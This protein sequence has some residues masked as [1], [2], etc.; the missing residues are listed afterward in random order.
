M[1]DR[2]GMTQFEVDD[3][4]V[5]D[6]LDASFPASDPPPWT[7]GHIETAAAPTPEPQRRP[8]TRNT[9]KGGPR[10]SGRGL[11]PA[12]MACVQ[13]CYFLATGIWP[14]LHIR[15]F[16]RVTG[17]KRK[18]Q[19]WLVKTVGMLAA[20]IGAGLL[21]STRG[22]GRPGRGIKLAATMSALGF[23]AI[24][25]GYVAK[26]QISPVYLLDAAFEAALLVGWST[27]RA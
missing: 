20:S 16:E 24:D 6:A 11:D 27:A 8:N 26:R 18:D 12:V 9:V 1:S 14:L 22:Q 19:R 4:A 7:A 15:S 17:G 2:E 13:G 5:D 21:A 3:A 10:T 25:A 23:I